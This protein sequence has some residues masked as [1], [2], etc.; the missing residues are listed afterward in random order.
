[1]KKTIRASISFL[2]IATLALASFASAQEYGE[3]SAPAIPNL[4]ESAPS[5]E[6]LQLIKS[7]VDAY[8]EATKSYSI[9]LTEYATANLESLSYGDKANIRAELMRTQANA[10][11]IAEQWNTIYTQTDQE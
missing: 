3:C 10:K 5:D 11:T 9:C 2:S 1:M 4:P 6:A 8:L 7:D